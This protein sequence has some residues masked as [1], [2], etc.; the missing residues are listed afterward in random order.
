[1]HVRR[2]DALLGQEEWRCIDQPRLRMMVTWIVFLS[3]PSPSIAI[4]RQDHTQISARLGEDLNPVANDRS[5]IQ[6]AKKYLP[7]IRF[8]ASSCRSHCHSYR[9]RVM[10]ERCR[11]WFATAND[12]FV[13]SGSF[14]SAVLAV[15]KK[16]SLLKNKFSLRHPIFA[17]SRAL[18]ASVF[19]LNLWVRFFGD[20]GVS[21]GHADL[22]AKHGKRQVVSRYSAEAKLAWSSSAVN[23]IPVAC[24]GQW[25]M[26]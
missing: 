23:Q 25:H 19:L 4:S 10:T 15:T 11:Q 3:Y 21:H 24:R 26:P 7:R 2:R 8:M 20:G 12:A 22:E 6:T 17:W 9:S 14:T 13:T 18:R 5:E 1:M 16:N